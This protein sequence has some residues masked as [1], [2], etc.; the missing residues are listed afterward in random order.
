MPYASAFVF[1]VTSSLKAKDSVIVAFWAHH[2]R[3]RA[4]SL[5]A[6]GVVS[7]AGMLFLLFLFYF[8]LG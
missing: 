8:F 1:A 7:R 5:A 2:S 3:P 6:V 4:A